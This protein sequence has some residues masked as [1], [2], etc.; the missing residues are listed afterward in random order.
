M[1]LTNLGSSTVEKS[2]PELNARVRKSPEVL[3]DGSYGCPKH[4]TNK[5]WTV[6]QFLQTQVYGTWIAKANPVESIAPLAV[7]VYP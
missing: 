7:H 4:R 5:G 6:V 2:Q 3:V 1:E